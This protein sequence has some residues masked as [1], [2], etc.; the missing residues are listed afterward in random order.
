MKKILKITAISLIA[1]IAVSVLVII[2]FFPGLPAYFKVKK[3]FPEIENKLA[4]FTEFDSS[5]AEIPD[6]YVEVSHDGVTLMG[7]SHALNTTTTG[8]VPFK[9]DDN[10]VVMIIKSEGNTAGYGGEY[11]KYEKEDYEHFFESLDIDMPDSSYENRCFLYNLQAKD[12]LKLRGKDLD[13]FMELAE[14]KQIASKVETAYL[15]E[16]NGNKGFICDLSVNDNYIYCYNADFFTEN[17][18]YIISVFGNNAETINNIIASI[19]ITEE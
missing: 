9:S 18:E 13:V 4:E 7:P 6:N 19:E 14:S 11:D 15:Y 12:C 16:E 17:N 8:M 10:L 1:L 3:E 2:V 5:T